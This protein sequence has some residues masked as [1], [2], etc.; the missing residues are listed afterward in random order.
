MARSPRTTKKEQDNPLL[1]ALRFVSVAQE[2]N[3]TPYQTHARLAGNEV[4]AFNGIVAAGYP[5]PL[6]LYGCP[7]TFK[8]IAALSKVRGAYTMTALD[9]DQIAISTDVFR[10]LV[11]CIPAQLTETIAPDP[12]NYQIGK[13]WLDACE[14]VGLFVTEGAQ[15][16][17]QSSIITQAYSVIGTNGVV[18]IEAAG[19][20]NTPSGLMIPYPFIK[21]AC[22]CGLTPV[23]FGFSDT[24]FTLHFE[25]GAWL[26][27]QLYLD[28]LPGGLG[29]VL[30][31]MNE[32]NATDIPAGLDV[33]IDAV[34]KFSEDGKTV[35]IR[36]NKVCSHDEDHTGAQYR[37]D[38]LPGF[39]TM[40][41]AFLSKLLPHF[42]RADFFTHKERVIFLGTGVRAML[43]KYRQ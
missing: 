2:E 24:S 21:A 13:E 18:I 17:L 7:H 22:Q 20:Y 11:P 39:A 30:A 5:L 36:E 23:S 41:G 40:N 27:T 32:H 35:C 34:M 15:T 37:L 31:Q 6:E 19:R 26:R 12:G 38:G 14:R 16:V 28:A 1:T 3:G 33:A 8:M 42:T 29:N 9:T 43:M 10:A 4:I 25:G